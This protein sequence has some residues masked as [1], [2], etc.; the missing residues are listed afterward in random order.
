M[1]F[2]TLMQNDVPMTMKRLQSTPKV[3]QYNVR[4]QKPEVVQTQLWIEISH[5]NLA[6]NKENKAGMNK[7][8]G[9]TLRLTYADGIGSFAHEAWLAVVALYTVVRRA[10]GAPADLAAG[11]L[12]Q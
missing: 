5:Q 1:K 2:G 6:C 11:T 7:S 12:C 9:N 4:F 3:Q 10:A 8:T